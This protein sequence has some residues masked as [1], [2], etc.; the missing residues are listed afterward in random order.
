MTSLDCSRINDLLTQWILDS[1]N[2]TFLKN[3]SLKSCRSK[4][5]PCSYL[6]ASPPSGRESKSPELSPV[7]EMKPNEM[8]IQAPQI[9]PFLHRK[10]SPKDICQEMQC[11]VQR[12]HAIACGRQALSKP[13]FQDITATICGFSIYCNSILFDQIVAAALPTHSSNSRNKDVARVTLQMFTQFWSSR[14]A[15]NDCVASRYITL[16]TGAQRDY[17]VKS[18]L[19]L[20]L[21]Q[22][23][24]RHP[25]LEF[26]R[27]S[28]EFHDQYIITVITRMF[29]HIDTTKDG[30]ITVRELRRSNFLNIM[31]LLD[32]EHDINEIFDYFSYEHFYVIYNKFWSLDI[33][34]DGKLN[35]EDLL[36]Y[37]DYA[38]TPKVIERV[39]AGYPERA[40]SPSPTMTPSEALS[41]NGN[42]N[43]TE[44]RRITATKHE[45]N[46]EEF[47]KFM[48]S[49]NDKTSDSAIRYWFRVLDLDGDGV[50]S[51]FE[52]ELFYEEQAAKMELVCGGERV[53]FQNILVLLNDMIRPAVDYQI[54]IRDLRKSNK[55]RAFF[56]MLFNIKKFG[57]ESERVAVAQEK[58]EQRMTDWE[59]YASGVYMQ[60]TA[61]EQGR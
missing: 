45:M 49:E 29:Y 36:K 40:K 21:Q 52:L 23:L 10:R 17:L 2:Q 19:E 28:A 34:G 30:R 27:E 41:P 53:A 25:G 38:L 59:R 33:D 37:D 60:M 20:L 1:N 7:N 14:F 9:E 32:I 24:N 51:P 54:T 42:G 43:G 61:S 5:D 18:D 39:I 56:N 6:A 58:A 22:I 8:E 46:Y 26:L 15:D 50:L 47:V 44:E 55:A 4:S 3:L 11:M 16:L 13:A 35:K 31:E 12:W 57:S 48:I